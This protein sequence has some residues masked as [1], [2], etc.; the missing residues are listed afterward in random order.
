MRTT[1]AGSGGSEAVRRRWAEVA[2][3]Y[4][5]LPADRFP[6]TVALRDA[7]FAAGPVDRFTLGLELLLDGLAA[8]RSG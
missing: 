8:H 4:R 2:Q 6:H 5:D 1:F 3:Y 7:L